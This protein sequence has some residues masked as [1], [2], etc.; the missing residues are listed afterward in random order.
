MLTKKQTAYLK[1]L[2][3]YGE[4]DKAYE[5]VVNVPLPQL[6]EI[7]AYLCDRKITITTYAYVIEQLMK[8]ETAELHFLAARITAE[9][10]DRM[11]G[12]EI[13]AAWHIQQAITLAP[14]CIE[15]KEYGQFY[16]NILQRDR[17][18]L[19]EGKIWAK[20]KSNAQNIIKA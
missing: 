6:F 1:R 2:L 8:K 5:L 11:D 17:V 14:D 15:Y 16:K 20:E 19:K 13:S 18:P 7:F 12:H 4:F 10:F 3:F 9:L